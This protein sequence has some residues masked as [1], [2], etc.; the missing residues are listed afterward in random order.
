MQY[1]F[2]AFG[3][4][5]SETETLVISTHGFIKNRSKVP[6]YEIQK[7]VQIRKK[8]LKQVKKQS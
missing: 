8:I 3:D 1:R 7:A 4:K 5:S 2:L 6:N